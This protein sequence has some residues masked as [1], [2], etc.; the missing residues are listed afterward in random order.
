VSVE[1]W[2]NPQDYIV[3]KGKKSPG[4]AEISDAKATYDYH[5]KEAPFA[6]GAK[7]LFRK[8]ELSKFSVRLHLLTRED[9][10]ALDVWRPIIDAV[11][12]AQRLA[13]ALSISHPQLSALGITECVVLSVSQLE[14]D[15]FGGFY[16][17]IQL[18]EFKGYPRPSEAKVEAPKPVAP[19]D[20]VDAEIITQT[21]VLQS[22]L[23]AQAQ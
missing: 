17:T 16:L 3:L 21:A 23:E 18:V 2:D 9:L 13:N 4:I 20:P 10:A 7:M 22:T 15:T 11:P 8:R 14:P 6:T 12:D 1:L 19:T 5:V